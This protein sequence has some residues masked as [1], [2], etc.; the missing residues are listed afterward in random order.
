LRQK[1]TATWW[2]LLV[3]SIAQL[4]LATLPERMQREHTLN[5]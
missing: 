3:S 2:L 5:F 1:A 4:L